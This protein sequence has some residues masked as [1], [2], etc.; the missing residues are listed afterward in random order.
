MTETPF[1]TQWASFDSEDLCTSDG[2][3]TYHAKPRRRFRVRCWF[4]RHI[5]PNYVPVP[6]NGHSPTNYDRCLRCDAAVHWYVDGQHRYGGLD[7]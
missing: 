2:W 7:R 3:A 4:G 1:R 6:P 5:L